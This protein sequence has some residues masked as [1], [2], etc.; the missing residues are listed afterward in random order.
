MSELLK[1]E[2]KLTVCCAK[3]TVRWKVASYC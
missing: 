1:R 3:Y 2:E